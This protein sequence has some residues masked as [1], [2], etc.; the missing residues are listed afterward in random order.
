MAIRVIVYPNR[1]K[2]EGSE[3]GSVFQNKYVTN[4]MGLVL[5]SHLNIVFFHTFTDQVYNEIHNAHLRVSHFILRTFTRQTIWQF[6]ES[7]PEISI[8]REAKLN[9]EWSLDRISLDQ[10]TRSKVFINFGTRSK[11]FFSLDRMKFVGY[12]RL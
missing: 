6:Y 7:L 5:S 9:G 11:V 10:I 2:E 3:G 4:F 8:I 12:F 1:S